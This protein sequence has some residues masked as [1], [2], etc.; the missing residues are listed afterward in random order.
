M[1]LKRQQKNVHDFDYKR[2]FYFTNAMAQTNFLP[3]RN[4]GCVLQMHNDNN[5]FAYKQSQ[6]K[7]INT[8]LPYETSRFT[9]E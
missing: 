3:R 5:P 4:A 2:I 6:I 7:L 8:T 9:V 1:Q